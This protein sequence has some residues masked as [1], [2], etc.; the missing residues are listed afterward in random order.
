[1]LACSCLRDKVIQYSCLLPQL[2][3][4]L[5]VLCSQPGVKLRV[6]ASKLKP[7]SRPAERIGGGDF[8]G[9]QNQPVAVSPG[10][11]CM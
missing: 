10:K 8:D 5:D 6:K 3:R 1:M 4:P 2:P 9:V 11:G 7:C